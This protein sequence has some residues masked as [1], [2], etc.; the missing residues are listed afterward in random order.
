MRPMPEP[1]A[2]PRRL[3]ELVSDV[4]ALLS[5]PGA[6]ATL[7]A[8]AEALAARGF[9]LVLLILA[10]PMA[11]PLP[12]PP[13]VNVALAVPLIL[14]TAQQAWGA[15][16]VWLP[17]RVARVALPGEKLAGVL[18]RAVPHIRKVEVLARPR[19]AWATGP[20]GV[21]TMGAAGLIMALTICVPVPLSNTVPALGIAL[22][23]AGE[24]SRDGVAV[25]AGAVIGLAWV[26]LLAAA[27]TLGAG[28]L[29]TAL[30]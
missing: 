28:L 22:M 7:G 1:R 24:L 26:A 5:D 29:A 27:A 11:L 16:R 3:S 6:P 4:A 19:L 8:L 21:R 23:A 9:G 10:L 12:V 13:G 25:L 30:A 2:A 15:R 20:A 17:A 14:L 18:A